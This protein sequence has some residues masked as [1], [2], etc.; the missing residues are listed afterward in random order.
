MSPP[1][2]ASSPMP[3]DDQWADLLVEQVTSAWRPRGMDGYIEP[4]PAWHDLNEA[5]RTEAYR[6]TTR[7]R[8]MEAALDPRG[9]SATGRAVLERVT[10][11]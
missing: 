2:N 3:S 6:E 5:E 1:P 10:R 4:H 9:L 7:L 11:R 8:L